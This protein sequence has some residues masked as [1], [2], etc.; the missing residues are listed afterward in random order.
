VRK[1]RQHMKDLMRLATGQETIADD[2][3]ET[4]EK[5]KRNN[6]GKFFA[7]RLFFVHACVFPN[8]CTNTGNQ[9]TVLTFLNY[10]FV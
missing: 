8:I 5:H 9:L 1:D 4:R 3:K 10:F 2:G 6:R 7:F